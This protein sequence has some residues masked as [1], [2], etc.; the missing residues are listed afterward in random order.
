VI[1][2]AEVWDKCSQNLCLMLKTDQIEDSLIQHIGDTINRFQGNCPVFINIITPNNGEYVIK[3]R[4]FKARPTPD[5]IKK[6]QESIGEK[7]V[8]IEV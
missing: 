4:R 1:P 5:L 6:L 8:W 2:L 7:N 3:S